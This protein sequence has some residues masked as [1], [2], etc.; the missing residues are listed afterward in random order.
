MPNI[1]KL[2]KLY[3]K[4]IEALEKHRTL[5]ENHKKKA[6][7]YKE[8]IEIAKGLALQKQINQQNLSG[9]EFEKFLKLLESKKSIIEALK[10]VDRQ[11]GETASNET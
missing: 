5:F 6:A 11:E 7:D 8:Q 2:E 1:E 10:I 3:T 9:E 4:E